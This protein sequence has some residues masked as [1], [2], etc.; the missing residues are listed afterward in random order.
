MQKSVK[1]LLFQAIF[2]KIGNLNLVSVGGNQPPAP[3]VQR[4]L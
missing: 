2:S 4:T 1:W 3:I